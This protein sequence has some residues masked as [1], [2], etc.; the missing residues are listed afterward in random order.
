M[1]KLAVILAL[2]GVAYYVSKIS[3]SRKPSTKHRILKLNLKVNN[4]I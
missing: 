4:N 1:K 2:A 3:K